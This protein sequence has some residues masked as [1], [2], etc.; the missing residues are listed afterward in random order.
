MPT[1]KEKADQLLAQG[2]GAKEADQLFGDI[3][4][5]E[6][7][8]NFAILSDK[9]EYGQY[10]RLLRQAFT[11]LTKWYEK[12][13][14][15]FESKTVANALIRL[16]NTAEAL[17]LKYTYDLEHFL[18]VD[19]TESGFPNYLEIEAVSND[20]LRKDEILPTLPTLSTLIRMLLDHLF[21]Y[22]EDSAGLL[23]RLSQRSYLTALTADKIFF[24][25]TPGELVCQKERTKN[26]ARQYIFT[27][28][29]FDFRTNLPFVY[30]MTFEQDAREE[31]LEDRGSAWKEFSE[32]IFAE[33][34]RA[35]Q[36]RLVA[37]GIDNRLTYIHPKVIKR[38]CLG[39]IYAGFLMDNYQDNSDKWQQAFK[40]LIE[41]TQCDDGFVML[42]TDEILFSKGEVKVGSI[43]NSKVRQVFHVPEDDLECYVRGISVVHRYALLPHCLWQEAA[44]NEVLRQLGFANFKPLT[45]NKEGIING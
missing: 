7:N 28:F 26:G 18:K 43:F 1:N 17:R 2:L 4:R 21:K 22:R 41:K 39:P 6:D 24:P 12:I 30:I 36:L 40:S 31:A 10:F 3:S 14:A 44:N 19:L 38:I 37:E 13:G 8:P 42:L 15:D 33:G 16:L 45:F 29:T 34:S 35:S 27:W 25:F 32:A 11:I 23:C 9:D 5:L 20:Y